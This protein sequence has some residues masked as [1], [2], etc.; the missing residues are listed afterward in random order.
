[1]LTFLCLG[2]S[3]GSRHIVSMMNRRTL[4]RHALWALPVIAITAVGSSTH[5]VAQSSQTQNEQRQRDLD[6][7]IEQRQRDR[8]I[9]RQIDRNS[10]DQQLQNQELQRQLQQQRNSDRQRSNSINNNQNL[11]RGL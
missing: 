7:Q 5:A 1:M 2:K 3:T 6:R 4:L 9:D 11:R 10:A 8:S